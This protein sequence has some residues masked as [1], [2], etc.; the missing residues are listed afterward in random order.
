MDF[1]AYFRFYAELN[2]FLPPIQR[3]QVITYRFNGHPGIKDPI[4]AQGSLT[5]RSSLSWLMTSQSI[6][7]IN[8][9]IL[10]AL[11]FIL[12]L[13]SLIFRG[14]RDYVLNYQIL[15]GLSLML[16]WVSWPN[17]YG[18]LALIAC[19]V[20]ISKIPSSLQRLLLS[21]GSS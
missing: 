20:I 13:P 6:L 12:N 8:C 21:N 1:T 19:T 15:H 10:I 4:E 11:R 5:P 17:C 9:K 2:D 7:A 18:C 16:I 14:C 3:Q